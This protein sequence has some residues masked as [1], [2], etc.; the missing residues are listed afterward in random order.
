MM[1][2]AVEKRAW[3]AA[4]SDE[5]RTV[6]VRSPGFEPASMLCESGSS[7]SPKMPFPHGPIGTREN[8]CSPFNQRESCTVSDYQAAR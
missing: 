4:T 8:L 3:A 1:G 6:V 7:T 5:K 2:Q